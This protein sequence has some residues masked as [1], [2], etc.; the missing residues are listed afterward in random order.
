MYQRRYYNIHGLLI[1]SFT[2]INVLLISRRWNGCG[3]ITQ[4]LV[5]QDFYAQ[6]NI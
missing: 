5:V 4:K 3:D 1:V 6:R 2:R